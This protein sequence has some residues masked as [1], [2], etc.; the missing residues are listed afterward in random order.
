VTRHREQ[1]LGLQAD[2]R[3]VAQG[4]PP[5]QRIHH[6]QNP[7]ALKIPPSPR[8]DTDTSW[9]Q[10]Q[11][12]QAATI[13]AVDYFHVHCAVTL[14]RLYSLFIIEVGSRYVHILGV[15]ANPNGGDGAVSRQT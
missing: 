3:R 13:L 8:R 9:R 12:A 7:S 5:A 6:P 14:Q 15:T 11:Q 4:R 1:L 2:P 10:F